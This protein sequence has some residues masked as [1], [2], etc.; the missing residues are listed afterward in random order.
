MTKESFRKN[1]CSHNAMKQQCSK[2][3]S[4]PS[5]DMFL[6]YCALYADGFPE[7][8]LYKLLQTDTC[9]TASFPGQPG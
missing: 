2:Y 6:K 3:D 8:C 7:D 4:T 5:P 9:L 1:L